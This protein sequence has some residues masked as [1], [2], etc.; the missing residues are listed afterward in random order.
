MSDLQV[1][2]KILEAVGLSR[3]DTGKNT[4]DP[5]VVAKFRGLG[6]L[7]SSVQTSVIHNTLNPV[8]NQDLSLYPKNAGDVLMLKVYDHDTLSKDNLLG[9]VE[10]PLE[11][12]FQQGFQD[13]WIQLMGRKGSWKKLVGGHPTWYAVPGQ[14]HIQL[15]FGLSSQIQST[16]QAAPQNM[17]TMGQTQQ[18]VHLQQPSMQPPVQYSNTTTTFNS[19]SAFGSTYDQSG[20]INAKEA[21]TFSCGFN[22]V[23]NPK[24][25]G[26]YQQQGFQQGFQQQQPTAQ[27]Y[28]KEAQTFMCGF[29]PVMNPKEYQQQQFQQSQQQSMNPTTQIYP[30][31]GI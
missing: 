11:R 9:M 30:V 23:M 15:W 24:G 20:Q 19:A 14:L 4:S 10:I 17:P 31:N 3:G 8:W 21:Q 5:F 25:Y 29:N 2:I 26:G 13:N 27:T 1:R 28:S 16:G 18:T 6:K 7:M 22:P 12:F